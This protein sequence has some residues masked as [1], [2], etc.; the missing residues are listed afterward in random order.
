MCINVRKLVYFAQMFVK[1]INVA[2]VD[3]KE[4]FCYRWNESVN[5]KSENEFHC[6]WKFT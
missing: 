1:R 2:T 4:D 6:I 5:V 3:I